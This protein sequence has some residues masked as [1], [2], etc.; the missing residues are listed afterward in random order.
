MII[1]GQKLLHWE[2]ATKK[3]AGKK[4]SFLTNT[5]KRNSEKW[6]E[7]YFYSW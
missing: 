4:G 6:V 1:E 3:A 5:R 7:E 2:M